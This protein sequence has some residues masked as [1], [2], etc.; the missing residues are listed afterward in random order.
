PKCYRDLDVVSSLLSPAPVD[1]LPDPVVCGLEVMCLALCFFLWL[2]MCFF[3]CLVTPG[4]E[5]VP[6]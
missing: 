6:V 4:F 1:A 5:V 3:D 2:A